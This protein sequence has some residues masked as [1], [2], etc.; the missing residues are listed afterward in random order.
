MFG[1]VRLF[2][3][4][5]RFFPELSFVNAADAQGCRA[6]AASEAINCPVPLFPE[7]LT[8]RSHR[9]FPDSSADIGYHI[10]IW[11]NGYSSK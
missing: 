7:V 5:R 8:L 1:V 4:D 3:S 2:L 9:V 6:N 11:G 10:K